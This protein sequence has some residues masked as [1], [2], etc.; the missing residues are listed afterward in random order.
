MNVFLNDHV[1]A[2]GESGILVADVDGIARLAA[3]RILR[4]VDK[5]QEIAIIEIAKSMNFVNGGD[6]R[7]KP[8]HDLRGKLKTQIHAFGADMQQ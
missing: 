7:T 4:P 6:G 2:A 1:A 5:P 8:L 3:A